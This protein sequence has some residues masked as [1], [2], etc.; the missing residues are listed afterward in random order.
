MEKVT[1][2]ILR[3]AKGQKVEILIFRHPTSGLQLPAGTVDPG[4]AP[5]AAVLREVEEETGLTEVRIV[6]KLGAEKIELPPDQAIL[7][8]TAHPLTSPTPSAAPL[9]IELG[10][11]WVVQIGERQGRFTAITYIETKRSS[12]KPAFVVQGWLPTNILLNKMTRHFYWLQPRSETPPQWQWS[13]DLGHVFDLRWVPLS[14]PP[15]LIEHQRPW[16]KWVADVS[17]LDTLS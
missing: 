10:R 13:S 1:A 5:E 2:L 16:L 4:E 9:Q 8:E 6:R 14:P 11:G 7:K 17:W 3:P 15:S 12:K